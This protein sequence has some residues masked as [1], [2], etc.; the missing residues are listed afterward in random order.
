M[1]FSVAMHRLHGLCLHM[2]QTPILCFLNA[3]MKMRH[4]QGSLLLLRTN[5]TTLPPQHL[6]HIIRL[7]AHQDAATTTFI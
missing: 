6:L 4:R 2:V 7:H 1:L 3:K 5:R